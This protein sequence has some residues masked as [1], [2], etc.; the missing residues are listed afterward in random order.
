M[1][2]AMILKGQFHLPFRRNGAIHAVPV[3]TRHARIRRR[4]SC[5]SSNTFVS[6][7]SARRFAI[8]FTFTNV[9]MHINLSIT[10]FVTHHSLLFLSNKSCGKEA[11]RNC[12]FHRQPINKEVKLLAALT[13]TRWLTFYLSFYFLFTVTVTVF[14]PGRGSFPSTKK[15]FSA[16]GDYS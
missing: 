9:A 15:K 4:Q 16:P 11:R 7:Q 12:K 10:P 1:K 14:S 6:D 5:G 3:K 8:S 2:M 13:V